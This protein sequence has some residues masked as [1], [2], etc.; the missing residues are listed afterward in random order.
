LKQFDAKFLSYTRVATPFMTKG[1]AQR[2]AQ[3]LARLHPHEGRNGPSDFIWSPAY[4]DLE[5]FFAT[6]A[7]HAC[8]QVLASDCQAPR[9]EEQASGFTTSVSRIACNTSIRSNTR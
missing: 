8:Q 4:K 3:R 7:A 1:K 6:G 2:L 9:K 5:R